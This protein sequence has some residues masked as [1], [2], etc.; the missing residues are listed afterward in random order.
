[1]NGAEG[2]RAQWTWATA[3]SG[4]IPP[5]ITPLDDNGNADGVAA[6]GLIDYVLA[7]G[8]SGIFALGGCGLGSWLTTKQRGDV[9][10]AMVAGTAHRVPVLVG[11]ML[12]AT[13]PA[14]EA[15]LQAEAEGADAVV[16]G[17]PYYNAVDAYEQRRHIEA[18]L[19]AVNLPV[20]LYNIPQCTFQPIYPETAAALAR[21]PRVMGIK[22]S[23]GDIGGFQRLL[24]IKQERPDFRVIQGDERVMGACMLLGAD[25]LVPGL[26]NVA[27]RYLVDMVQA[28][29]RGD[30]QACKDLQ[31]K[32]T[33]VYT[34]FSHG[35]SLAALT[36]AV[37]VLGFGTG[38]P[39]EPYVKPDSAQLD[40]ISAIL[41]RHGLLE[42]A[43]AGIR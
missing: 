34:L 20:L 38:R 4:V 37:S 17:S 12:P 11:A 13:G 24:S 10:R 30:V 2:G 3:L 8:C 25:G 40:A 27:P 9:V 19:Q 15:A 18:I 22:D 42:A 43:T 23:S 31:T 5:L 32:V 36:A 7:N 14:R 41:R 21:E 26:A 28:G 33:D 6:K 39:A 1:M 35:R 29:K 16:I